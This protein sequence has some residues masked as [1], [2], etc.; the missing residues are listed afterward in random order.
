MLDSLIGQ[1]FLVIVAC[2]SAVGG[3]YATVVSRGKT[4]AEAGKTSAEKE[5]LEDATWITRLDALSNDLGRLQILSDERFERLVE[6]ERLITDHVQW[7]F[8]VVRLLRQHDMEI[9]DPPSLVYVRRK[10]Q[11]E[12]SALKRELG[13]NDNDSDSVKE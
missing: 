2:I 9:D 12:K 3:I 10:L 7:D 1:V 8:H 11:E 4:D 5:K 6:I 13:D